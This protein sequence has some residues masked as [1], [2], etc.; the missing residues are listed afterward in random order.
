MISTGGPIFVGGEHRS[1]TTLLTVIL[2]SHPQVVFGLELDFLEPVNL[3]PHIL[4][5]CELVQVGQHAC[6]QKGTLLA[7]Y[8]WGVQFVRQCRSFGLSPETVQDLVRDTMTRCRSQLTSLTDRCALVTVLGERRRQDLGV[9]RWGFKIQRNITRARQLGDYW[10]QAQFVHV[11]R[12]G[13]DVAASHVRDHGDWGYRHVR[14]A[15]VGWSELVAKTRPLLGWEPFHEI[16]YED[17]VRHT[18]DTLHRLLA[19]LH[20]PW[21]DAVLRHS[22]LAHAMHEAFGVDHPSMREIKQAVNDRSL[23]RYRH[24][25]SAREVRDF[26]RISGKWLE[27]LNYVTA[28]A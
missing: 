12:D 5:C 22:Q 23:Q 2:D 7:E 16:K 3:G 26:E 21:D 6:L 4:E 20:L 25:L 24:D 8:H 13:R 14:A 11:V 9:A 19:F 10:P 15:A 18:R 17:L 1:G 28:D 27:A